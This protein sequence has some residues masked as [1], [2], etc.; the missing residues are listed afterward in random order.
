M[1]KE[2]TRDA[3]EH[4]QQLIAKALDKI[5][6]SVA[7]DKTLTKEDT[8]A[9]AKAVGQAIG[10]IAADGNYVKK[11]ATKNVCENISL[12]D[13]QVKSNADAIGNKANSSD[14]YNKTA[15]DNLISD[16][17]TTKTLFGMV[18]SIDAET[19]A[20]TLTAPQSEPTPESNG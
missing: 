2:Y 11:S 20:V 3:T 19:G 7:V 18:V 6:A 10:T 14:V 8:S 13:T 16:D 17:G 15:I 5:G 1:A 12:L 9:E 4:G